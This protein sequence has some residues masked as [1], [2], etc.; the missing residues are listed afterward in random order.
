M[1]NDRDKITLN[2]KPIPFLRVAMKAALA[3]GLIKCLV[4]LSLTSKLTGFDWNCL[5]M[6]LV[7]MTFPIAKKISLMITRA[8]QNRRPAKP[9]THDTKQGEFSHM[10]IILGIGHTRQEAYI[11]PNLFYSPDPQRSWIHFQKTSAQVQA[12]GYRVRILEPSTS[13]YSKA[14]VFYKDAAPFSSFLQVPPGF[15]TLN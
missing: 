12:S 8:S 11:I 7:V 15:L 9:A 1:T 6:S 2:I 10:P 13:Y 14:K 4:D 5:W 3:L